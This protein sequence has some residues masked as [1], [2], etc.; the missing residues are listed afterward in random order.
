MFRT[1]DGW[2][3]KIADEHAG[4]FEVTREDGKRVVRRG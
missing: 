2:I 3:S 1:S 4:E